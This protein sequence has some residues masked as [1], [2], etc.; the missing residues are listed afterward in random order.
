MCEPQLGKRGLYRMIGGPKNGGIQ[1]LP[2]LWVLNLSD[3]AHTLLDI[4]CRSGLSFEAVKRAADALVEHGL[5][6]V[7]DDQTVTNGR[8]I[9][10]ER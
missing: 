1:E 2:L 7:I 6:Q 10:N 8:T 4:S 3:S 5:L 9:T